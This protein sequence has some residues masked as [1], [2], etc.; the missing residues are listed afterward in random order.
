MNISL[1][2][3]IAITPSTKNPDS[4]RV[5]I[6]PLYP[7]YGHTIGNALRRVLLSS[8]EGTGI[9]A[10][11]IENAQHE[12]MTLPH[13]K[14][15]V[16]EIILNLKQLCLKMHTD[17]PEK[18]ILNVKGKKEVS[19]SDFKANAN[20]EIMNKDFHIAS[21]THKDAEL[22][23]EAVI[24]R[25]LGFSPIEEREKD[26]DVGV[27]SIDTVFSPVLSI[28]YTVEDV[29]VGKRTDYDKLTFDITTNGTVSVE[30]AIHEATDILAQYISFIKDKTELETKTEE[31]NIE[32]QE[33]TTEKPKRKRA[34]KTKKV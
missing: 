14:E 20:V 7:G 33:V 8:L 34:V 21:L 11:K 30:H 24:E 31:K 9:T 1:P 26:T 16:L 27:I 5:E 2:S 23:I 18:L 17:G 29:R 4:A 19:A 13:V 28:G 32:D 22:V 25:G 10:V 15:E 6:Y 3:Q 12:F